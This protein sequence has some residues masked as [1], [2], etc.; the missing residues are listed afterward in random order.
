MHGERNAPAPGN[1]E[2]NAIALCL[3]NDFT[4]S[5]RIHPHLGHNSTGITL[6]NVPSD[7]LRL[8]IKH[9]AHRVDAGKYMALPPVSSMP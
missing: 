2:G 4:S 8:R 9:E 3:S 6:K 1:G 7:G 5:S